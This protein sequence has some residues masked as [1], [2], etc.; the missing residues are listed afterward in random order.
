MET[1]AYGDTFWVNTIPDLRKASTK[2]RLHLVL[3]LVC[4]LKVSVFQLLKFTFESDIKVVKDE[5]SIFMGYTTSA[6]PLEIHRFPPA[7]MLHLWA[8]RWPL[9]WWLRGSH[10]SHH[11]FPM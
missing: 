7:L 10:T 4:F 1:L 2:T 6:R 3:S 9:A 8:T 5:A 11:V